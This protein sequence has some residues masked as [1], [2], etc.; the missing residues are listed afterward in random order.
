MAWLSLKMPTS[1][2][3]HE[4]V[5]GICQEKALC[6]WRLP[7]FMPT[8]DPKMKARSPDWLISNR[9]MIPAKQV[10]CEA[11]G[12]QKLVPS[13]QGARSRLLPCATSGT[14]PVPL[15]ARSSHY[16]TVAAAAISWRR[17]TPA[18]RHHSTCRFSCG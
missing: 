18:S 16:V 12:Q 17:K 11:G 7:Q 8:S 10:P 1:Q 4:R 15:R 6:F 14:S 3:E 13:R 2:A 9:S 5:T